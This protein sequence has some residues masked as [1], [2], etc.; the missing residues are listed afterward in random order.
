VCWA[1]CL[2]RFIGG[3]GVAAEGF[4]DVPR[5]PDYFRLQDTYGWL[6]TSSLN[7]GAVLDVLI[8]VSLCFYIRRLYT[9]YNLPKY[10]EQFVVYAVHDC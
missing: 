8:A 9:P 5:E 3:M 6:I 10:A 2:L 7:V 1:L 4:L